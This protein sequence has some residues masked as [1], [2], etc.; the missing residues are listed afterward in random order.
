MNNS[1]T[2][3]PADDNDPEAE[4]ERLKLEAHRLFDETRRVLI[5]RARRAM[6]RQALSHGRVTIDTA[7]AAVPVPIGFDPK[8][9]GAVPGPLA[10]AGILRRVGFTNTA[11][12]EG[13]AR[14]VSVWDLADAHAGATWLQ[15][16]PDLELPLGPNNPSVIV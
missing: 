8:L 16:N 15:G 4:G 14:P 6:V 11:R 10:Q 2:D 1:L 9:F 7:R 12:P 3:S 13:H 5:R